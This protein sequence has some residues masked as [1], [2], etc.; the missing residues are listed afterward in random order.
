MTHDFH[1]CLQR[2]HD[3]E[4]SDIWERIYSAA[5]P[6]HKGF[7]SNRGD[8][9]LQRLGIDRTVILSTGKAVYVDE[10]VR[11]RSYGDILLEYIANDKYQTAGWVEKPLFCDYIA[12]AMLDTCVCYLLPV[13]Q[14]QSAWLEK[15]VEWIHAYPSITA[16]NATYNTISCP[17]PIH[18]LY[19]AIGQCFKV[20][21]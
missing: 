5:F 6:F 18:T 4:D 8:G 3:A 11:Q 2:S 7:V 21:F 15:K 13:P 14:L 20:K 10:K 9:Q 16:K 12:Y 19:H 17:V 1:E